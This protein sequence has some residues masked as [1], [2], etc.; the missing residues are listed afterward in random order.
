MT[1]TRAVREAGLREW[2]NAVFA[3]PGSRFGHRNPPR[4]K[5]QADADPARG[6]GGPRPEDY[7]V[8]A[9]SQQQRTA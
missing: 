9:A 8:P 5:A 6:G 2:R 4:T 7:E 1:G 3:H